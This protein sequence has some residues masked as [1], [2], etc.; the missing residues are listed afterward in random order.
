MNPNPLKAP[1]KSVRTE[2]RRET[3]RQQPSPCDT[4]GQP[5]FDDADI[6]GTGPG[7]VDNPDAQS[8][9]LDPKP[10]PDTK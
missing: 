8:S 3:L 7:S 10:G 1:S 6:E 5:L 4:G 9:P 2:S